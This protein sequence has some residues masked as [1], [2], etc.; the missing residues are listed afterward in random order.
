MEF[1][2]KIQEIFNSLDRNES[3]MIK[4]SDLAKALRASGLIPTESQLEEF[5]RNAVLINGNY[6]DFSEF[7]KIA[8]Q[9]KSLTSLASDEVIDY[10]NSFNSERDDLLSLEDL[11]KAL[12]SSGDRLSGKEVERLFKDFDK[13]GVGKVSIKDLVL[14]LLEP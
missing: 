2:D 8:S 6:I 10:F 14:G 5:S 13:E 11:K 7:K 9:C 4:S 12:C 1:D 3:K